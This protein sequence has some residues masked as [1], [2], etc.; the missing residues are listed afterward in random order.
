MQVIPRTH[1]EGHRG[2]S[3]YDQVDTA[4]NVF[5]TEIR[6]AQRDDSRAVF[7]E[8][9]PNQCSLHDARIMHGSEPN[10]SDRR[11]CGYTMRFCSSRVKFVYEKFDGAHVVYLARGRD[12]G[13]NQYADPTKAHPEVMRKRGISTMY[14]N[15]H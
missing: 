3:D 4:R 15:S 5:G 10:L 7:I 11:R 8:L 1:R 14:K 13:G 6:K 12:L 2:F 9:Q